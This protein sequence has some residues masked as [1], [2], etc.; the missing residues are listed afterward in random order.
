MSKSIG[1]NKCP[2]CSAPAAG[3]FSVYTEKFDLDLGMKV[4]SSTPVYNC[5]GCGGYFTGDKPIPS[6]EFYKL[7]N[8][9]EWDDGKN[10]EDIK[11]FDLTVHYAEIGE[12]RRIHGWFNWRTKRVSQIG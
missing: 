8:L 2:G 4:W 3:F 12:T 1:E 7:V 6:A 9:N 11:Y 5:S 10:P